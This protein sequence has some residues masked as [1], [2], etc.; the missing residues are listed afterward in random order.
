MDDIEYI[1]HGTPEQFC[2][3]AESYAVRYNIQCKLIHAG[4]QTRIMRGNRFVIVNAA[5]GIVL[6][7]DVVINGI[8][9]AD[10]VTSR[11]EVVLNP[12]SSSPHAELWVAVETFFERLRRDGW[13]INPVVYPVKPFAPRSTVETP[14]AEETPLP[15]AGQK[16]E[17]TQFFQKN[18]VFQSNQWLAEQYFDKGRTSYNDLIDEWLKI[19]ERECKPVPSK[20]VDSMRTFI[21]EEKKRRGIGA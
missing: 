15:E 6:D 2:T 16:K 9:R 1:F 20:P 14:N 8:L 3:V 17:T 4:N 13:E 11:L 18:E 19:R 5:S 7:E 12:E 10:G 21:N